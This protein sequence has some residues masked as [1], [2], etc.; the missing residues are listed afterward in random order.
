MTLDSLKYCDD[1]LKDCFT[2]QPINHDELQEIDGTLQELEK[3][4]KGSTIPSDLKI[5]LLEEINKI[6]QSIAM[7]Q[8]KG[9]PEGGARKR[10]SL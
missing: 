2:E 4:I 5:A 6:R 3:L 10:Y 8:I 9:A 7:V 1:A